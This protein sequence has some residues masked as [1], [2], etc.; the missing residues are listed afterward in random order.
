MVPQWAGYFQG[1]TQ[2]GI[3]I[4]TSTTL[5]DVAAFFRLPGVHATFAGDPGPADQAGDEGSEQAGEEQGIL[6]ALGTG[7]KEARRERLVDEQG[8][9]VERLVDVAYRMQ[10]V[11]YIDGGWWRNMWQLRQGG[12][13][14]EPFY[15]DP[16]GFQLGLDMMIETGRRVF[17]EKYGHRG[18]D[19]AFMGIRAEDAWRIEKD[20]DPVT[21]GSGSEGPYW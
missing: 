13:E 3:I 17:S 9:T 1:S 5:D 16:E 8:E 11:K 7:D 14:G 12:G 20:W 19:I 2:V 15:R 18:C 21:E 10:A 6:E 4:D